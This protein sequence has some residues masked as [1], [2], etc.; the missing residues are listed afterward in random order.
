MVLRLVLRNVVFTSSMV[1]GYMLT[2]YNL[3]LPSLLSICVGDMLL[4]ALVGL[5]TRRAVLTLVECHVE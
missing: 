5:I 2:S 4:Q 1:D 3:T